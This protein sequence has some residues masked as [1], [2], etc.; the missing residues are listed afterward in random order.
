V[1]SPTLYLLF[2]DGLMREIEAQHPGVTLA[3]GCRRPSQSVAAAMQAD[4]LVCVCGSV[5]QLQAVA[6]TIF[7]YSCK[8]RFRLNSAKSAVMY[9]VIT[10]GQWDQ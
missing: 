10:D 2:I 5:A 9:G 7:A 8:W 1:I 3:Q 6:Q 4:D